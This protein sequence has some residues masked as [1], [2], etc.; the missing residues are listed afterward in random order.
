[1]TN[2][3]YLSPS[4]R[5]RGIALGPS[6]ASIL[7]REPSDTTGA[8]DGSAEG[9]HRFLQELV[10]LT[11]QSIG[12]NDVPV[13]ELQFGEVATM[14]SLS[15]NVNAPCLSITALLPRQSQPEYQPLPSVTIETLA[16][17]SDEYEIL[18]HADE[19]RY[20]V[21]RRI[22]IGEL[23]DERSVMDAILDT[24]DHTTRWFAQV[25]AYLSAIR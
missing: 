8:L 2:Q 22:P 24:S 17:L 20:V 13:L 15:A 18:W 10:E 1:M 21:I 16:P 9:M 19:G 3:I 23:K 14:T 7:R 12:A 4:K 6:K 5:V 25:R 11:G